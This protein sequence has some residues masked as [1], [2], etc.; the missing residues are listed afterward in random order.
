MPGQIRLADEPD[1]ECDIATTLKRIEIIKEAQ[2]DASFEQ[3]AGIPQ[4]GAAKV[5]GGL[6]AAAC[7]ADI[8]EQLCR[9]CLETSQTATNPFIAPCK[10]TGSLRLIHLDCLKEWLASKKQS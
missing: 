9:I 6:A 10:C 5:K 7:M 4:L 3:L 2:E 8:D 1:S